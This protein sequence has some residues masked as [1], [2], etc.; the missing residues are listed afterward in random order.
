MN[1]EHRNKAENNINCHPQLPKPAEETIIN[2]SNSPTNLNSQEEI[3]QYNDSLSQYSRKNIIPE[4]QI[5]IV[6]SILKKKDPEMIKKLKWHT[7]TTLIE[8][9]NQGVRRIISY[10]LRFNKDI[11]R[12]AFLLIH[13][14]D[15]EKDWIVKEEIITSLTEIGLKFE[16]GNQVREEIELK[17]LRF[18]SD[19]RHMI[20]IAALKAVSRLKIKEA[21]EQLKSMAVIDPVLNV[22]IKASQVLSEILGMR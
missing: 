19:K 5:L 7:L 16:K 17:V 8:D 9:S 10:C 20:R 22:R 14:L 3:K 11:E 15:K 4:E 2:R 21:E 1:F 6:R 12:A 13:S 18:L